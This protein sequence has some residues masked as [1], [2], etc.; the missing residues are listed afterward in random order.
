MPRTRRFLLLLSASL[1]FPVLF[2]FVSCD[3]QKTGEENKPNKEQRELIDYFLR[4]KEAGLDKDMLTFLDMRDSLTQAKVAAYF[5]HWG[6]AI[7]GLKVSEWAY[8]WPQVVGLPI[9]EDSTNGE[10]RRLI[11]KMPDVYDK[12]GRR[13]AVYPIIM[14]RN[15]DGV[16]KVSNASRKSSYY[17]T[18]DGD[19]IKFSDFTYHPFFQL[20]PNFDDLNKM[21]GEEM[22]YEMERGPSGVIDTTEFKT[23]KK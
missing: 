6:R 17:N 8:N 1:L 2:C 23:D 20:P 21:P 9:I 18:I 10:W 13:K 5:T 14:F 7:N 22:P 4:M 3:S 12:E 15:N 16:W 11:F 19:T